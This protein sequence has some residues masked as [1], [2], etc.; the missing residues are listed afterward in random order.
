MSHVIRPAVPP[1]PPLNSPGTVGADITP[2]AGK[3]SRASAPS[4]QP[5]NT[6]LCCDVTCG[7]VTTVI[8]MRIVL[9]AKALCKQLNE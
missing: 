8:M 5:I 4:Q 6:V 7:G 1:P 3:T 2:P 9:I